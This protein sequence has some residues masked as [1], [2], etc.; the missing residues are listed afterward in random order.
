MKK[1]HNFT[2]S[3]RQVTL[4][5]NDLLQSINELNN[6]AQVVKEISEKFDNMDPII[7]MINFNM[8]SITKRLSVIEEKQETQQRTIDW[9]LSFFVEGHT[10]EDSENKI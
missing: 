8:D 2:E 4:K 10:L 3:T 7:N 6:L 5:V 9:L 1:M